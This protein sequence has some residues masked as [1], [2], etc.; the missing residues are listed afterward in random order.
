MLYFGAI[1]EHPDGFIGEQEA[2]H[3]AIIFRVDLTGLHGIIIEHQEAAR[4]IAGG[5][6]FSKSCFN[7]RADHESVELHFTTFQRLP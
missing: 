4:G 5:K 6:F 2:A 3:D 1:I 7:E